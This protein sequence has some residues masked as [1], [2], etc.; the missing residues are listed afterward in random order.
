[1]PG[2][3]RF[4]LVPA[5]EVLSEFSELTASGD[6]GMAVHGNYRSGKTTLMRDLIARFEANKLMVVFHSFQE[7]SKS[8]AQSAGGT[9]RLARQLR[10]SSKGGLNVS[11]VSEV[12]ALCNFAQVTAEKSAHAGCCSSSTKRST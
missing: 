9:P 8:R 11:A 4:T 5:L 1:M 10:N 7:S 3:L 6:V 12:E 2:E